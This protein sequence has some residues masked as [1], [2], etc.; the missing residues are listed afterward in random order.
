MSTSANSVFLLLFYEH[1]VDKDEN[2]IP[3]PNVKSVVLKKVVDFMQ[4]H[5]NQPPK[6]IEK[7]LKVRI[8]IT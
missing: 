3:L 1:V 7:P 8:N 5:V 2:E 6:E 4:Y